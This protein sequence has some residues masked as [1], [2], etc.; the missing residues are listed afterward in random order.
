MNIPGSSKA[1]TS[2]TPVCAEADGR[3]RRAVELPGADLLDHQLLVARLPVP[4]EVERHLAVRVGRDRRRPGLELAPPGGVLRGERADLQRTVAATAPADRDAR[5]RHEREGEERG[6]RTHSA[7]CK[8]GCGPAVHCFAM[9]QAIAPRRRP[10]PPPRRPPLARAEDAPVAGP[11]T[12]LVDRRPRPR[13]RLGPPARRGPPSPGDVRRRRPRSPSPRDACTTSTASRASPRCGRTRA[14]SSA[15][16][17]SSLG[18]A[19]AEKFYGVAQLGLSKNLAGDFVGVTQLSLAHDDAETFGGVLQLAPVRPRRRLLRPRADRRLRPHRAR[20]RGRPAARP[21]ARR[22]GPL[23]RARAALARPRGDAAT[24]AARMQ[25]APYAHTNDFAGARAAR[26]PVAGRRALRGRPAARHRERGR[27][28]DAPLARARATGR[29]P[30]SRRSGALQLERRRA[31]RGRC[32][33]GLLNAATKSFTGLAQVG[34]F[35]AT[36]GEMWAPVA[37]GRGFR[38]RRATSTASRRSGL[39]TL[40]EHARGRAARRR[41]RLVRGPRGRAARRRRLQRATSAA[42]RSAS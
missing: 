19:N 40:S 3:H 32:R 25:L 24:S 14:S 22:G 29:S 34:L 1:R 23:P 20:L 18:Q 28:R 5:E 17:S 37:G 16:P 30:A 4:R 36:D 8:A 39:G 21:G 10:P 12:P 35:S 6:D 2:I 42:R 27:Q 26:R 41:E 11:E 13:V 38:L 9:R 31:S 15:R 7:E 33:L